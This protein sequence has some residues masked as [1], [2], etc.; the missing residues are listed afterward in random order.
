MNFILPKIFKLQALNTRLK[1]NGYQINKTNKN[2]TKN[3]EIEEKER[4][5]STKD[6]CIT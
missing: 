2:L 6:L 5:K 3:G 4:A 1:L